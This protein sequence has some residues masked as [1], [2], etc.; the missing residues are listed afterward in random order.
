[1]LKSYIRDVISFDKLTKLLHKGHL[2]GKEVG[3]KEWGCWP[4]MIADTRTPT[5]IVDTSRILAT[6]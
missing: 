3:A 5:V 4:I 6:V 2:G 1:M